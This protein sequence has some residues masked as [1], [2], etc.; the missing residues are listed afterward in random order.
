MCI[1]VSV[2]LHSCETVYRQSIEVGQELELCNWG[3][4]WRLL[5]LNL[6]TKTTQILNILRKQRIITGKHMS[7]KNVENYQRSAPAS[8]PDF[9]PVALLQEGSERNYASAERTFSG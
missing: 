3:E 2:A 7:D 5:F 8:G 9:N 6:G 4:S 1:N